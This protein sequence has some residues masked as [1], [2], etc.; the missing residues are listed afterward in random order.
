MAS[1]THS[2][3]EAPR[4]A[5]TL[6]VLESLSSD[7]STKSPNTATTCNST[8]EMYHARYPSALLS[9]RKQRRHSGSSTATSPYSS[10]ASP[11]S[12]A[13]GAPPPAAAR[14]CV[15]S[16]LCCRR[17]SLSAS[18]CRNKMFSSC[19]AI[20]SN[21]R[22]TSWRQS[23]RVAQSSTRSSSALREP[24]RMELVRAWASQFFC[25]LC[26]C[27]VAERGKVRA[28]ARANASLLPGREAKSRCSPS[29]AVEEREDAQAGRSAPTLLSF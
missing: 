27:I 1:S 25:A 2:A 28:R 23:R 19:S 3:L 10:P 22:S 29:A 7:A 14:S 6:L 16:S 11:P 9:T 17:A 26:A 4:M 20:S 24:A 15:C 8:I 5:P 12:N 13:A 18:A 21:F